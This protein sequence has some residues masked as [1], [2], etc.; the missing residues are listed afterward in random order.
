MNQEARDRHEAL[1]RLPTRSWRRRGLAGVDELA[2]SSGM[3][4]M[5]GVRIVDE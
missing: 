1:P 2:D 4:Q 5:A 3:H